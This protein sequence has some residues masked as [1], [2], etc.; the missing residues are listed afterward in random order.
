MS[1]ASSVAT[2]TGSI[3]DFGLQISDFSEETA[4]C[5][6]LRSEMVNLK[7]PMEANAKG[8]QPNLKL[9]GLSRKLIFET[10]DHVL[11]QTHRLNRIL[12]MTQHK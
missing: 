9:S 8:P 3:A 10:D 2:Q 11:I 5:L 7:S 12:N 1:G 4:V 6:P